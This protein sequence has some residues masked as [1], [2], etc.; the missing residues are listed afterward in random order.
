MG[1]RQLQ[2]VQLPPAEQLSCS[3]SSSDEGEGTG[4]NAAFNPFTFLGDDDDDADEAHVC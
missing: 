1:T 2:K 4:G 3:H